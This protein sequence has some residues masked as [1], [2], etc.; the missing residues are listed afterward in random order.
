MK[1]TVVKAAPL[2]DEAEVTLATITAEK[3][4]ALSKLAH[5]HQA[6]SGLQGE[7]DKAQAK[8]ATVTAEKDKAT[9]TGQKEQALLILA[10]I[11]KKDK[12]TFKFWDDHQARS[13]DLSKTNDLA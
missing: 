13:V 11:T 4:Q 3:E 2:D 12:S 5:L 9:V 1:A 7:K 6:H 8:I 10:T